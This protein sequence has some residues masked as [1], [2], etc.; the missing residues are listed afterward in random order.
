[1]TINFKISKFTGFFVLLAG[2]LFIVSSLEAGLTLQG[3]SGFIQVPSHKTID[4]KEIELAVHTR[5]Y[6][7]P[8]TSEDGTLTHL[9]FGFSPFR[10]FEAGIQKAIDSRN[11]ANDPDPTINFKVKL[12]P[13]GEGEFSELAFGAVF[14]TNPN[15]YHTMYLTLGGFGLGWNFGG[16]PGSGVANYGSYNRD[17]KE[18]DAL[19]LLIGAE[20]PGRKPG[21]RGYRSQYYLD[22]NGD[23]FSLGW[24]YSSHRGF[25]IDA[26][27]HGK[28]SYDD[29]FDYR[30]LII[31]LGANF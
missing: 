4:A 18:P 9:A 12:P 24:R 11:D 21:E 30:P 27:V 3:P 10:D 8:T 29:F 20:F 31:G 6:R 7:T 23:V 15:N 1:M 19:C 2:F 13:V 5:M 17:K 26:A 25:W 22:Y 14:D 28:S 16:N